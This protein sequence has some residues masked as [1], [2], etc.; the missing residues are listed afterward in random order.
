MLRDEC[1]YYEVASAVSAG[2]G[3]ASRGQLFISSP[4]FRGV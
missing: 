2:Q 3:G 4:D 1:N